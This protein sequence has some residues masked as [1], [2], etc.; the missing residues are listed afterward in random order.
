MR[1]SGQIGVTIL[2][3][4]GL[5]AV[6]YEADVAAIPPQPAA[7][8]GGPS[9]VSSFPSDIDPESRNRLPIARRED[10]NDLGRTL[11]DKVVDDVKTGRSLAGFQGPNGIVVHSPQI[12]ETDLRKNDY[13]RFESPLGRRHYEVAILVV[14][15]ELN[16][17]FEWTAH[18]PAALKAGVEPALIDII[19][20]KRPLTGVQPKD[21][22]LIRLGRE[23]I[24]RRAVQ[25]S[26][27]AEALR[28]FGR[29]D[30][31]DAVSIMAHY[32]GIAVLLDAFN[33][34]LAP[35]QKPLLP[36]L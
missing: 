2:L 10:L 18:E 28:L 4:A 17:Q 20:Y 3:V 36:A 11:F 12:A 32:A 31:V 29:K 21:A 16:H 24:G 22:A 13:L 15:R 6:T 30:L 8:S 25:S 9:T 27:L 34:Q 33:Q 26:T 14:A 5:G 23:V 1:T 35:G 7:Q 19:K